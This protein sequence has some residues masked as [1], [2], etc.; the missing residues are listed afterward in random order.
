MRRWL[1]ILG[2]GLMVLGSSGCALLLVPA[3]IG[4]GVGAG[5]EADAVIDGLKDD[6][7][8]TSEAKPE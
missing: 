2:L 1:G 5:L 4:V 3:A 6:K 7:K 8:Q